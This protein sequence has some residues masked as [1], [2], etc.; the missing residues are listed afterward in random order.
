MLYRGYEASLVDLQIIGAFLIVIF[1]LVYHQAIRVAKVAFGSEEPP[2][3]RG[4]ARRARV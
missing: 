4:H 2:I 1:P 3:G